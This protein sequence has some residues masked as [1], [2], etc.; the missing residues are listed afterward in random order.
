MRKY[1]APIAAIAV[2]LGGPACAEAPTAQTFKKTGSAP[3]DDTVMRYIN[4]E[5]PKIVGGVPAKDGAYPWQV[6]LVVADIPDPGTGH[7]CGGS[8][9]SDKWIVTAAHCMPGLTPDSLDVIAGT[10]TLKSG[11]K[12]HDVKR[13]LVHGDYE[14]HAPQDSDI[15]L[16]ELKEPLALGP[17]IKA[18]AV[19][20]PADEEKTLVAGKELVVTGWGAMEEGGG[21]TRTL[22]E[23]AVP[24]VTKKSCADPLAYG[25]SITDNMIC[26]GLTVGGK[27]S[28]QGDSGGPLVRTADPLLVGVVSWGEGCARP[29]KPGVYTRISNFK[30]WIEGCVA[31]KKC[32]AK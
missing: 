27:D 3:Y 20:A 22:Q 24:F 26:A 14:K 8:I 17:K 16:I 15:A 21:V 25:D 23:V 4:K 13:I 19:L 5:K 1:L 11:V 10:N 32:N 29:G 6:S 18:V 12:R 9:Y 2:L 31:G 28:C 7:F 30:S